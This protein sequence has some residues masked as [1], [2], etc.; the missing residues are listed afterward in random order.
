MQAR[1][2]RALGPERVLRPCRSPLS[3]RVPP[4]KSPRGF[5]ETGAGGSG[6][7]GVYLSAT[8]RSLGPG[9]KACQSVR[10]SQTAQ[11]IS[12]A[13]LRSVVVSLRLHRTKEVA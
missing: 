7:G 4:P 9:G 6:G 11:L 1:P 2:G 5:E 8:F 3:P 13:K 10:A 12:C